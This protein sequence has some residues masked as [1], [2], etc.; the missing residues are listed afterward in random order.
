L[1]DID[2]ASGLRIVNAILAGE[3]HA[4]LLADLCDVR[5]KASREEIIKSLDGFWSDEHLFEL[6]QCFQLYKFHNQMIQECERE[7]EKILQETIMSQNGGVMPKMAKKLKRKNTYKNDI[8]I[9]VV[10]YL[11]MLTRVDIASVEGITGIGGVTALSIYAETGPDL[12]RFKS[13]K[14]FV[15]WL[16]L[17]PNNKISGGKIIS[18]RV[19]KK[20]N[21]AGLVFRMAAMSMCHNKG[22][23]GDYYRRIRSTAGKAKAIVAVAR[24][25][26]VIYY[27]MMT[28][29]TAYNPQAMSDYQE[30]YNKQKIKKIE[31][32]LEKLKGAAEAA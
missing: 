7:I 11:Y 23:L 20:K 17:S 30:K 14:H 15:S 6:K 9:D 10:N 13:E 32:Y 1:S 29:K 18:S 21:Y 24:K 3:R 28:D 5:V 8:C 26:A 31:K 27:R 12:S 16:G 4:E 2:G 22:P 19:Q 25:L